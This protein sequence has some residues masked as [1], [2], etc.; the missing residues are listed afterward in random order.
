M[1]SRFMV[2]LAL[3]AAPL[4]TA[5]ITL[6][7]ST[8]ARAQ[9]LPA[10]VGKPLQQAQNLARAGNTAGALAQ[11]N[12]ARAAAR[13][14][15]EQRAVGQMA[16]FV[17]TRAGNFAAAASEL[18]RIG[19]PASQLAPLYY[20]ARQWDKA[21]AAGRRSGQTTIVGQSMLQKGDFKGA[22]QVYEQL[23]A[24][25]P[26]VTNLSNLAGAQ[27]KSGD[28]A[29]YLATSAR[30]VRL[31][32]RPETWRRLLVDMKGNSMPA[33]AKL[34]L[35]HLMQQTGTLTS[36][37]D[38]QDFAK[39]AIVRGQPGAAAAA[40]QQAM[41]AGVIP[42]S[43]PMGARLVQAAQQ[44]QAP[45][46]QQAAR[47]AANPATAMAAGGAFLGAGQ[48]PQ[49]VA[50]FGAA[51]RGPQAAEA[52]LFQGI[53]QM[54]AGQTAAAR[55]SFTAVPNGPLKDIANLWGLFASTRA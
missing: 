26:T 22:V 50:A 27:A 12:Q 23:V 45:L 55:Q 41:Q 38:V 52:T 31:D 15:A 16:A 40:V 6:T 19:A 39:V 30:I 5:A 13:S 11:V 49:A 3:A 10:A 48:F 44:R 43:D 7:A 37:A 32:P 46:L 17:Q 51:R 35:Y 4:S 42:A 2:A 36:A 8:A 14:P 25:N 28:R 24:G 47:Q 53:A 21:I 29:G 54:R 20:Q 18:E 1:V 34:A 33:D 9:A